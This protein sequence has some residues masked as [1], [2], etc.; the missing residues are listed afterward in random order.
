M[1]KQQSR[2]RI[3]VATHKLDKV[4]SDNV[5]M[6]IQVGKAISKFDLGFKGD[7]TGDNISEK[8]PMYCELTAQYWAWKNLK[9]VEYIGL[10]HYRRYFKTKYTEENL[11]PLLQKYDI[12]LPAPIYHPYSMGQKIYRAAIKEDVAILYQVIKCLYPEYK[13][14]VLAY[15]HGN[16]DIAF[17]MFVCSKELFNQFAEWQFSILFECEKYI[18]FSG[19]SRARRILGHFSE[20]LLPIYCLHHHLRVKYE[21]LVDFIGNDKLLFSQFW[22]KKLVNKLRYSVVS[23]NKKNDWDLDPST[24]QG[25]EH[26][27]IKVCK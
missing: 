19:Y 8:N 6:P 10:C 13:K 16:K 23:F 2:A 20:Y 25:L 26:D 15:M 3:L 17:N 5:Y 21:P 1:E 11:K 9:D 18:R 22:T 4:Y 14:S 7:D 27:N 24:V 12:I